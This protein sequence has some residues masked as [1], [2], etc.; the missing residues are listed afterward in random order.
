VT[1]REGR[2]LLTRLLKHVRVGLGAFALM[3]VAAPAHGWESTGTAL[4]EVAHAAQIVSSRIVGTWHSLDAEFGLSEPLYRGTDRGDAMI[5]LALVCASIVAFNLWF[6]R[7]LHC[8]YAPSQQGNRGPLNCGRWSSRARGRNGERFTRT[9][10][11]SGTDAPR[12]HSAAPRARA[13]RA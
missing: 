2:K 8:A 11:T 7:H 6:L 5:I 3:L 12:R 9:A 10:L 1:R 13:L 4:A